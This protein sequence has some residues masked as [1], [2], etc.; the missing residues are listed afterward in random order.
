MSESREDT[1]SSQVGAS[2]TERG[3]FSRSPTFGSQHTSVFVR[4]TLHDIKESA[5]Q[6]VTKRQRP[7]EPKDLPLPSKTPQPVLKDPDN[8]LVTEWQKGLLNHFNNFGRPGIAMIFYRTA[9]VAQADPTKANVH[10]QKLVADDSTSRYG[11]LHQLMGLTDDAIRALIRN[12]LPHDTTL[13]EAKDLM[14]FARDCMKPKTAP[15]IYCMA[16]ASSTLPTLVPGGKSA[17]RPH[18]GKYLSPVDHQQMVVKCRDYINDAYSAS[19]MNQAIDSFR[20]TKPWTG[21]GRK[22]SSTVFDKWLPMFENL[23]AG[24]IDPAKTAVPWTKAPFEVGFA[25]NTEER[26]KEH[27]ANSSTNSLWALVHALA[28]LSPNVPAARGFGFPLPRQWELI[29]LIEDDEEYAQ[30]GEIC[31]SLLCSSYFFQ[32]G[33]NPIFAGTASLSK[34]V[35]S[36]G[37]NHQKWKQQI[38]HLADRIEEAE[39]PAVEELR[40][41]Q[42]RRGL[43]ALKSWKAKKAVCEGLLRQW[44]EVEK[45]KQLARWEAEGRW[46]HML[47]EVGALRKKLSAAEQRRAL[48]SQDKWVRMV[49]TAKRHCDEASLV[50]EI[51]RQSIFD[52]PDAQ[53]IYMDEQG[54]SEDIRQRVEARRETNLKKARKELEDLFG[55]GRR[56]VAAEQSSENPQAGKAPVHIDLSGTQYISSESEE[57]LSPPREL[58]KEELDRLVAKMFGPEETEEDII[59]YRFWADKD[60]SGDED[61]EQRLQ[62]GDLQR[63]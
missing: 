60:V 62:Y 57:E 29:P 46:K 25:V 21:P 61:P 24:N 48:A 6:R 8:P 22:F 14:R 56:K 2:Q 50:D 32:G 39:Y 5:A 16:I 17:P 53:K 45:K 44:T 1:P 47:R 20:R 40:Y 15:S 59:G 28:R 30:L 4:K 55:P 12:S 33:L 52:F 34:H 58:N 23:Y 26:L 7:I 49:A 18:A 51:C 43:Q 54:V 31:G 37:P 63:G 13:P 41:A 38:F 11:I 3:R 36:W 35:Q 27:A 10:W 9:R 42:L 19:D